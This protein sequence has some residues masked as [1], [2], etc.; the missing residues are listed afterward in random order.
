MSSNNKIIRVKVIYRNYF[1]LNSPYY[2]LFDSPPLNIKFKAR[3]HQ[4]WLSKFFFIYDRF[5]S[6]TLV[7]Q[8]A[9]IFDKLYFSRGVTNDNYDIYYYIGLLPADPNTH[10]FV[11]D[12][13]H[14]YFL[15]LNA[16]DEQTKSKLLNTFT[17]DNCLAI[18]PLSMAAEKTLQTYLGDNYKKIAEKV[19]V[20]YPA[21]PVYKDIYNGKADFSLVKQNK[22]IKFLF[23]GKDAHRKG[24]HE[25][26]EAF[27]NVCRSFDNVDLYVVSDAPKELIAK[28]NKN[29]RIHIYKTKFSQKEVIKK[30]FLTCDA[31]IMPTHE[32]TFGMVYLEALSS[33]IPIILT[34]QFATTEIGEHNKNALYL[35]NNKLF[36]DQDIYVQHRYGQDY[37]LSPEDEKK[38][39]KELYKQMTNLL[40]H[41]DLLQK[42]KKNA[43]LEFYPGGKFSIEKRNKEL[44]KIFRL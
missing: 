4:A 18:A 24:L 12:L 1:P 30:F 33:G 35:N 7:K 10:K 14:I 28:Y 34:R 13:E 23:V 36:L 38:I 39:V 15:T 11:V 25:L 44:E 2:S 19:K 31:F 32:D 27:D 43:P 29:N 40:T 9:A 5:K 42:M 3:K 37:V 6:F 41:P 20:V 8:T 17:H 26:L 16:N 21:F 22:N